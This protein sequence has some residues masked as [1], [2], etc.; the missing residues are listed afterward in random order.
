MPSRFNSL[1][2][3]SEGT[4]TIQYYN[5][6]LHSHVLSQ[7]IYFQRVTQDSQD[8]SYP[9]TPE[10]SWWF[11]VAPVGP[12]AAA[13]K[14]CDPVPVFLTFVTYEDFGYFLGF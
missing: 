4:S 7:S 5:I 12:A 14:D 11:V 13:I 2:Q 8:H 6:G 9:V 1:K 10:V 3:N